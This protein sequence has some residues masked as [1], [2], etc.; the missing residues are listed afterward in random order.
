M[1]LM[2]ASLR[3][4]LS[5]VCRSLA[6]SLAEAIR[7]LHRALYSDFGTLLDEEVRT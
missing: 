5:H 2:V 7:N 3:V 1:V 6:L 4:V